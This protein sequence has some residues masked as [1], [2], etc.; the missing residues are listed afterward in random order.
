MDLIAHLS[1]DTHRFLS[2]K[3]VKVYNSNTR[4]GINAIPVVKKMWRGI[5]VIIRWTFVVR[6]SQ[7]VALCCSCYCCSAKHTCFLFMS[8]NY[9]EY[10][11]LSVVLTKVRKKI[12]DKGLNSKRLT[13]HKHLSHSPVL[14]C[15]CWSSCILLTRLL[16]LW[17]T[18]FSQQSN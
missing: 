4:V 7:R 15:F 9:L 13:L 16:K 2:Q 5:P 1:S 10:C 11:V 3:R 17:N 12:S 14:L 6:T 18:F 8:S